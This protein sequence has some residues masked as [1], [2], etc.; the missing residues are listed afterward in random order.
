[1]GHKWLSWLF[2]GSFYG[3]GLFDDF[4]FLGFRLLY[5][6]LC[7]GLL[8]LLLLDARHLVLFLLFLCFWS[9]GLDRFG[10]CRL[11]LRLLFDFLWLIIINLQFVLLSRVVLDFNL[12]GSIWQE[13]VNGGAIFHR[14]NISCDHWEPTFN[15]YLLISFLL[16]IGRS[17]NGYVVDEALVLRILHA[18]FRPKS[19][20]SRILLFPDL[21][22]FGNDSIS[23]SCSRVVSGLS[24]RSFIREFPP[25]LNEP[26]SEAKFIILTDLLP[27]KIS[28]F[29][30]YTYT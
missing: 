8:F 22:S 29:K 16:I 4:L 20:Y 24:R 10:F 1:M 12:D 7:W 2:S 14:K 11:L 18:I 5:L 13:V 26:K 19:Y 30:L 21:Y 6:L 9:W 27:Q 17:F 25:R 28:I 15:K 3:S 23:K